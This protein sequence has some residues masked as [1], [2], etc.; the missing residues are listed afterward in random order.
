MYQLLSYSS[1]MWETTAS[2]GTNHSIAKTKENLFTKNN[3]AQAIYPHLRTR[4]E[5]FDF[6]TL[7]THEISWDHLEDVI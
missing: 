1:S 6:C 3:W 5:I 4:Q 2:Q 7:C